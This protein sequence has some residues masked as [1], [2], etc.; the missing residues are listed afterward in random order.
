MKNLTLSRHNVYYFQYWLPKN[1]INHTYNQKIFRF[2]LKTSIRKDAVK[3]AYGWMVILFEL[4][5]K[6]N[7]N[8]NCFGLALLKMK[9]IKTHNFTNDIA[10][11]IH[12]DW[13]N[14]K[15]EDKRMLE[16][17][18][19]FIYK[20]DVLGLDPNRVLTTKE[21]EICH[22]IARDHLKSN[23]DAVTQSTPEV[24]KV[25]NTTGITKDDVLDAIQ[26]SKAIPN[27]VNE[28]L[29]NIFKIWKSKQE[30]NTKTRDNIRE[31]DLFIRFV[32]GNTRIRK[33]KVKQ[34]NQYKEFRKNLPS[35]TIVDDV[36]VS[37]LK[38]KK[39]KPNKRGTLNAH[40]R[41]VARFFNWCRT[42]AD[43][44]YIEDS[45][46][47]DRLKNNPSAKKSETKIRVPLEQRDLEL[48]FNH[49]RYLKS[50]FKPNTKVTFGTFLTSAMYWASLISLFTGARQT[51]I[52]Q[53]EKKDI[54]KE[55]D[56]WLFDINEVEEI[57]DKDGNVKSIKTIGSK[58]KIPIHPQL[59]KLGFLDYCKTIKS[60]RIFP[61]EERHNKGSFALFQSRWGKQRIVLGVIPQHNLELRDF[62]SFRHTVRTELSE[63]NIEEGL[64]DAILGHTSKD[65]S[66]GKTYDHADKIPYKLKAI[67]K[68]KYD[69]IDFENMIPWY[70]CSF[71]R[72]KVMHNKK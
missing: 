62:H 7:N 9:E 65:R 39:G 52:I 56:V 16:A 36:P 23:P 3:L 25:T 69:F 40:Y 58:R 48:L 42:K 54:I 70:N 38:K 24:P 55:K 59:K 45:N 44:D 22:D 41:R 64:I 66:E 61:D 29:K 21:A 11:D 49:S 30:T 1:L 8:P 13:E 6:Y 37:E 67:E 46:I 33:L 14:D 53:L 43:I 68:L 17:G 27:D 71:N 57:E 28:R 10:R 34:I 15:L 72:K 63:L 47:E 4:E 2:S 31:V 20:I 60:G 18:L 32:G 12:A 50:G 5:E 35:G 19:G 26:E 51:E